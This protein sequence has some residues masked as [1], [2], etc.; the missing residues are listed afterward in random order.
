MHSLAM[1]CFLTSNY[2]I[3]SVNV[4]VIWPF[5]IIMNYEP[6]T[7]AWAKLPCRAGILP[8]AR[9]IVAYGLAASL[10]SIYLY[11][12]NS[13]QSD[14]RHLKAPAAADGLPQQ[15]TATTVY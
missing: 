13:Q 3:N 6:N 12:N 2:L 1:H 8:T 10:R 4:S 7:A 5:N 11:G 14:S 9:S 15:A